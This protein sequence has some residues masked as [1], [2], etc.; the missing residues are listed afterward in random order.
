MR[1]LAVVLSLAAASCAPTGPAAPQGSIAEAAAY[2][3]GTV[4]EGVEALLREWSA[5]GAEGRWNDLKTLYADDPNFAW[6]ENGVVA[7][8]DYTSAVA[9]VDQVAAMNAMIRSEVSDIVVTPLAADAAAFRSTAAVGF[10]S[11]D[12]SFDFKGAFTGVAILRDGRWLFL[13]GHLSKAEAQPQ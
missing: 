11:P 13:N 12:F 2:D 8:A 6:I 1:P 4:K 10:V 5:A 7:Y 9:G 3:D